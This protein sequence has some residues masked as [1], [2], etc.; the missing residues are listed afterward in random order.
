MSLYGNGWDEFHQLRSSTHMLS[1][2]VLSMVQADDFED[3]MRNAEANLDT[4]A[5]LTIQALKEIALEPRDSDRESIYFETDGCVAYNIRF[6]R[7]VN[8]IGGVFSLPANS[9][10][11]KQ[12]N[13]A[14]EA[15][16]SGKMFKAAQMS[17]RLEKQVCRLESQAKARADKAYDAFKQPN[18]CF[19]N[20]TFDEQLR[21][22]NEAYDQVMIPRK[23]QLRERMR[24]VINCACPGFQGGYTEAVAG[25]L[26]RHLPYESSCPH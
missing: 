14:I 11:A 7:M 13:A 4:K 12:L 18:G 26:Y 17:R 10:R 1:G 24:R 15:N 25:F 22:A 9:G 21:L 20:E 2:D 8:F 16:L 19:A 6:D 5:F 3:A 23:A